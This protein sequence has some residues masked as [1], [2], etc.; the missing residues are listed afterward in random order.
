MLSKGQGKNRRTAAIQ[1]LVVICLSSHAWLIEGV[2]SD[3]SSGPNVK[4]YKER[5]GYLKSGVVV[6]VLSRHVALNPE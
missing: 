5:T 4:K 6:L 1:K 3:A 2:R